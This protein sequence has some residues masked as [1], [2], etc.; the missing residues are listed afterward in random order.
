VG[1]YRA[2]LE[3]QTN[4]RL[5]ATRT[6][7]ADPDTVRRAQ[8]AL[9]AAVEKY[10]GYRSDRRRFLAIGEAHTKLVEA[11]RAGASLKELQ[12]ALEAV[13]DLASTVHETVKVLQPAKETK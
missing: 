9:F 3:A 7:P 4:A 11:A 1:L 8:D 6:P 2:M 5:I 10:N 13:L 12:E